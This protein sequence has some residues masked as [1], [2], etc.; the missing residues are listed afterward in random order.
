LNTSRKALNTLNE[1][2]LCPGPLTL[3]KINASLR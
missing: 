1:P 2:E 3:A